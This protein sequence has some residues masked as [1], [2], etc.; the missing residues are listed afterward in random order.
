MRRN[1]T[2][3]TCTAKKYMRKFDKKYDIQLKKI[4]KT[5]IFIQFH[6]GF[7]SFKILYSDYVSTMFNKIADFDVNVTEN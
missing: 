2:N 6:T 1:K 5:I 7:T 3:H 4:V